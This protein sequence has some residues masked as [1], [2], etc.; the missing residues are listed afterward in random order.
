MKYS[1]LLFLPLLACAQGSKLKYKDFPIRAENQT[2]WFM[3][4]SP[5]KFQ[6]I[7][8]LKYNLKNQCKEQ[9][10]QTLDLNDK[11]VNERLKSQMVLI[12]FELVRN[13]ALNR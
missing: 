7:T 8:C 9:V 4:D 11:L 13:C 6:R 12:N 2:I 10:V 5:S 3:T 1:M